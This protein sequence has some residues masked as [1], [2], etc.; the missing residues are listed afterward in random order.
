MSIAS[1]QAAEVQGKDHPESDAIRTL[2]RGN[3]NPNPN[4]NP[5]PNSNPN[6]NPNLNLTVTLTP[7]MTLQEVND[8]ATHLSATF[9]PD[10]NI[11]FGA[12][13]DESYG[14]EL[15]VTI[16]ATDFGEDE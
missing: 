2:S 11:I 5:N 4:P 13:V 7:S 14:D 12:T 1:S 3:Y 6:P 10:A 16:V 15:T 9:D 8:V